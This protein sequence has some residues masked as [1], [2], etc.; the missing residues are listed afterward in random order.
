MTAGQR[1]IVQGSPMFANVGSVSFMNILS[2]ILGWKSNFIF[3]L[4]FGNFF[5]GVPEGIPLRAEVVD[6]IRQ[7][8][9]LGGCDSYSHNF[10]LVDF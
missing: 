8:G 2:S 10:S 5:G 3:K 6:Q 1:P 4:F 7:F 9:F